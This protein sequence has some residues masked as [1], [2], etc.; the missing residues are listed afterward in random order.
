MKKETEKLIKKNLKVEFK[1]LTEQDKQKCE[2]L[3]RIQ[4]L[5][6]SNWVRT[7]VYQELNRK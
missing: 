7:L 3:A 4:G 5:R 2:E 1:F 6:L